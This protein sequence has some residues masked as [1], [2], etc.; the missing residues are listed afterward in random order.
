MANISLRVPEIC[1]VNGDPLHYDQ[2]LEGYE[3]NFNPDPLG[4]TEKLYIKVDC[5]VDYQLQARF[6]L[7]MIYPSDYLFLM[8][9]GNSITYIKEVDSDV[10]VML[11]LIVR[12]L[13]PSGEGFLCDMKLV[14]RH[15]K[16]GSSLSMP[17]IL[18]IVGI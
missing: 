14:A 2:A 10:S 18:R 15:T 16:S 13:K 9:E 12:R 8:G 6:S 7:S 5:V 17:Q 3:A 11:P 1:D 4:S